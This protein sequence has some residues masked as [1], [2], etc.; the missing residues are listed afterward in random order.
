MAAEAIKPA[1]SAEAAS[2]VKPRPRGRTEAAKIQK[3]IAENPFFT[4]APETA[5]GTET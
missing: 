2:T 3:F 5:T 4:G 1:D